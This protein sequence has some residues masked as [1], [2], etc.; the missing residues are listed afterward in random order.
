MLTSLKLI[1]KDEKYP[2]IHN[3]YDNDT[4]KYKQQIYLEY[5]KVFNYHYPK[6]KL[7]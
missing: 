7:K 5:F 2:N 3:N 6:F 4:Y 1:C